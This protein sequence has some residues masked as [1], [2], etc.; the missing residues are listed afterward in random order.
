M[1][2]YCKW[3][4][5][6]FKTNITLRHLGCNKTQ[7]YVCLYMWNS[8]SHL[9][10]R[11]Y[12]SLFFTKF[13]RSDESPKYHRNTEIPLF[14]GYLIQFSGKCMIDFSFFVLL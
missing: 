10:S 2:Y 1:P 12:T 4:K 6:E 14:L 5:A 7:K 13:K 3:C 11:F 9:D 8:L